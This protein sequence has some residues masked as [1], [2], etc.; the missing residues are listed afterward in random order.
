MP[1]EQLAQLK[2]KIEMRLTIQ[3]PRTISADLGGSDAS[4]KNTA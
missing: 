2:G 1:L 3:K 4:V